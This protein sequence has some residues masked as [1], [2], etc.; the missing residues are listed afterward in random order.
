MGKVL[1]EQEEHLV[2]ITINRPEVRNA[3]DAETAAELEAAWLRFR[4]DDS[5]FVAVVTGAGDKAF[6]AGADLRSYVPLAGAGARGSRHARRRFVHSGHGYLGYTRGT[7][8]FKPIVA[9]INGDALAGGLEIACFADF[10]IAAAHARFGVTCRRWN[11]GLADGGT[12]RLPRI[13]GLGRAL[14]L[15]ITGRTIDADEALGIGLVNEVVPGERLRDRV[16]EIA[17]GICALPQAAIRTDKQAVLTGL[18]RPLEDGLRIEAAVFQTLLGTHDFAEGARAF[19]EKRP[20]QF[21][22]ED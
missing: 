15:I 6:C 19:V 14:E 8:I 18:G 17:R 11:V 20:P 1:Y 16:R 7:D 12:Q 21:T 4:D 3:I 9:A 5:A 2:T 13:V 22:N 10:R